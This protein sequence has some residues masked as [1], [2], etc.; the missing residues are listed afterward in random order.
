MFQEL[1]GELVPFT[2]RSD[3]YYNYGA[4]NHYQRLLS[5]GTW[6]QAVTMS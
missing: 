2:G 4:V 6:V 3:M 5:V 1:N